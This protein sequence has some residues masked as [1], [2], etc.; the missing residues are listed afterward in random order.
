MTTILDDLADRYLAAVLAAANVRPSIEG[1]EIGRDD[2]EHAAAKVDARFPAMIEERIA[3]GL[4]PA[5]APTL[6]Q[7]RERA[8]QMNA[9]MRLLVAAEPSGPPN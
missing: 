9:Q 2:L 1:R 4:N 8:I 3:A 7:V 5:E 6:D